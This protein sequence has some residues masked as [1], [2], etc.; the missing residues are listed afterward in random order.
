MGIRRR[1]GEKRDQKKNN[2]RRHFY[3]P[4]PTI[5]SSPPH[6]KNV[7]P[8]LECN[9]S[10]LNGFQTPS[11]LPQFGREGTFAHQGQYCFISSVPRRSNNLQRAAAARTVAYVSMAV[12]VLT[13]RPPSPSTHALST[14]HQSPLLP[15][16]L[17]LLDV[18][19]EIFRYSNI[20]SVHKAVT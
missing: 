18:A 20:R 16:S 11:F 2:N 10:C 9:V 1:N 5:A 17:L 3:I 12:C 8:G 19:V 6:P 7:L 4:E 15:T 14:P 13:L